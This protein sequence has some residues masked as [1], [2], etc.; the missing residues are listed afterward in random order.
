MQRDGWS[1]KTLTF[2]WAL[3]WL[4]TADE[5]FPKHSTP[6]CFFSYCQTPA[7]YLLENI[8]YIHVIWTRRISV[9]VLV[10]FYCHHCMPEHLY[11]NVHLNH[12]S[13]CLQFVWHGDITV[14]HKSVFLFVLAHSWQISVKSCGCAAEHFVST[15]NTLLK[16]LSWN[17]KTLCVLC[18]TRAKTS[19]NTGTVL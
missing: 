19:M 13:N 1:L 18:S 2:V 4:I 6:L 11:R 9:L 12:W 3:A 7:A 5:H 15:Y 10:K 16:K 8:M 17:R 14:H